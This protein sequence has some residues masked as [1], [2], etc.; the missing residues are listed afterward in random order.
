MTENKSILMEN[1]RLIFRNFKGKEGQYNAEGDRNFGV[2]LDPALAEQMERDGWNIKEMKVREEG[3][4]PEKYLQVRVNYKGGRPPKIVMITSK[5]RTPL[6]EDEV[7][8]LDYA[9]IVKT[10]LI[11]N[12][13]DWAVGGK[14]GV[15][16]YLKTLYVTVQEDEL[17]LKYSEHNQ[18]P[19]DDLPDD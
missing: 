13:Y 11:V 4:I 16:A 12:P 18:K 8:I 7:E 5:N 3:D 19:G 17:E 14:T 9:D 2:I 1:V 15:S 6:G 10:D